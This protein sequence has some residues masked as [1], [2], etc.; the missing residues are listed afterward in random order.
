MFSDPER[1]IEQFNL[2]KGM[3]IADF[4]AGSGFYSFAAAEAVGESGRV[5]SIDVQKDL[6]QKLKNEARNIRHLMNLEIVWADLEHLGGTRLRESSID[7]VIASNV[8]FQLEQKDNSCME[9]RRILKNGGRVLVI[10]W[11]GS[12]GGRGPESNKLFS[13]EDAVK[14]FSKHGFIVD[15]DIIVGPQH[16]G[17][18]FRK[19]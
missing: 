6:L 7:A 8:F 17:V 14:L 1:N 19:Q 13:R 12:I 15:K 11:S 3:Y 9:I 16:Y 18:I 5:Y 2:G 4:G 10:D